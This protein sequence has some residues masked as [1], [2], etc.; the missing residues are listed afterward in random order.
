MKKESGVRKKRNTD[1]EK[2]LKEVPLETRLEV[3]LTAD[4]YE[5][6]SKGTYS[7]SRHKLVLLIMREVKEWIKDG[8]SQNHSSKKSNKKYGNKQRK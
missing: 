8:M 2:I 1:I 6:W 4:D 5:N 3:S 7:G